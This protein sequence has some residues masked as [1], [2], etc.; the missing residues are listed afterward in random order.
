MTDYGFD[1]SFGFNELHGNRNP[2]I[3]ATNNV[4]ES[5]SISVEKCCYDNNMS[6]VPNVHH[7]GITSLK[8]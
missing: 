4:Q 1:E 7:Q 5:D 6:V 3:F 2:T 8:L